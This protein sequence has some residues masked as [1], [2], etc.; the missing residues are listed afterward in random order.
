MSHIILIIILIVIAVIVHVVILKY[1]PNIL[2]DA[3]AK[4]PTKVGSV[5]IPTSSTDTTIHETDEAVALFKEQLREG[6]V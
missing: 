3:R 2:S 4:I 1:R 5:K 6:A